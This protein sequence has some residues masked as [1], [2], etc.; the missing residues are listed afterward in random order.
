MNKK[1]NIFTTGNSEESLYLLAL[2]HY[3]AHKTLRAYHLLKNRYLALPQSKYLLAKCC[4]DLNKYGEAEAIL[5]ECTLSKQK[6]YDEIL[7]EYGDY[8]CFV[9]QI[10]AH[11]YSKTD[12]MPQAVDFHKKSLRL[13]PFLCLCVLLLISWS[14]L[15]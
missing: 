2:S 11:V 6:L 15:I 5:T 4:L 12:R 8:S 14:G 1:K 13:N 9:L 3:R 10:L 7:K